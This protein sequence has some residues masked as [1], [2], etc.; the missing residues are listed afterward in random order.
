MVWKYNIV[1]LDRLILCLALR[2]SA[3]NDVQVAFFIIPYLLIKTEEFHCQVRAFVQ[4]VDDTEYWALKDWHSHHVA[5]Q[6]VI[7]LLKKIVGAVDKVLH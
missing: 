7:A 1:P 3:P 5:F 6:Q 2:S 4:E